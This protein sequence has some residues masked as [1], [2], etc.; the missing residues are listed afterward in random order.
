MTPA[1]IKTIRILLPI[2]LVCLFVQGQ[3]S[4]EV[5]EEHPFGQANPEAPQQI[6]DFEKLIGLCDC[7]SESRNQDKSWNAPVK[8]TWKFKYI[9]NGMGVQDETIK[10][11]NTYSGSI[12]QFDPDSKKWYVH[13][14]SH[15]K[16]S[17]QL[18]V[19]V[20]EKTEQGDIVLYKDSTAPNGTEGFYRLTF[21]DIADDG[22]KWVGE[23]TDTSE[24]IVYPTWKISCKKRL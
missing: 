17:K 22:F 20:G 19:W 21:Y 8:M 1:P 5:S 18:S 12:R 4:Y 2:L 10:E 11:D 13:Y 3:D 9:M 7:L 23:W 6:K 15:P 16:I 14:Y 24:M